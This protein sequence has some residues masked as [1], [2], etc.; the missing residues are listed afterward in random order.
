MRQAGVKLA[1]GL[2]GLT[3]GVALIAP[4]TAPAGLRPVGGSLNV[5][6]ANA[7]YRSDIAT[8]DGV[9]HMAVLDVDR[10]TG[11][12]GPLR[13]RRLDG[14]DWSFVGGDL[15]K[16]PA[17]NPDSPSIASRNGEP[18]VAATEQPTNGLNRVFVTRFDG[19]NWVRVTDVLNEDPN[20]DAV[21]PELAFVKYLSL[22]PTP[23][24]AF[25][26]TDG[27]HYLLR[28]KRL[29]SDGTWELVGGTLNQDPSTNAG[30]PEIAVSAGRNPSVY[31]GWRET[32]AGFTRLYVAKLN[33]D[34]T[35]SVLGGAL[36]EAT[37]NLLHL[38]VVDGAPWVAF[39]EPQDGI[40]RVR[41]RRWDG[42]NWV[43]V[44][45]SLLNVE[46]VTNGY[47]TGLQS[48]GGSVYVLFNQV[49]D[50]GLHIRAY[51]KRF[52]GADWVKVGDPLGAPGE[53][54]SADGLAGVGAIPYVAFKDSGTPQQRRVAR[55]EA[56]VCQ[57][58]SLDVTF[59]T[60][61]LAV[62]LSC[63][64]GARRITGS[65]GHG[66]LSDLDAPGG[67]VRYA[68]AAGFTGPDAFTFTAYDGA[69]ESAPAT[70]SL[71]VLGP[72]GDEGKTSVARPQLSALRRSRAAF[73]VGAGG[74]PLSARTAARRKA[75]PRGTTFSFGLSVDAKVTVAIQRVR[76]GRKVGKRCLAPTRARARK[77][78]C[79]RLVAAGTLS[80]TG[81]AGLNRV[82][83]TGRIGR[84]AL[85]PGAYRAVFTA[86][87]AAGRSTPRTIGFEV[88]R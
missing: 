9:P 58:S 22:F 55:E 70:V 52:D 43:A 72:T 86:A 74:T 36:S 4:A 7:T 27:T 5:D 45:P 1:R 37:S 68:P 50:S 59:N 3:V 34:D 49:V 41:V 24:V 87:N 19:T 8:V 15:R 16:P 42:T 17:L 23:Y 33:A 85:S 60:A 10:N 21:T 44:G 57:S 80:R 20:H 26:E 71:N 29:K 77:P 54:V 88:V 40:Q 69:L 62:P 35:W 81:H 14:S 48:V 66:T 64:E 82:A 46:P 30:Y 2:A 31:I 32:S 78:R 67:T 63:D 13:V 12:P 51:L 65:P 61:P 18:W 56:P 84:R 11:H 73:A 83:F 38:V 39:T 28:V 76:T 6:P 75:R 53:S 79:L 25:S 47:A